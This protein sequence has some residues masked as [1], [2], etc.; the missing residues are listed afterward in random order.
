MSPGSRSSRHHRRP[1]ISSIPA[2]PAA[3]GTQ[4]QTRLGE[5]P[6]LRSPGR[7]LMHAAGRVGGGR[8]RTTGSA[9]G[10]RAQT[11]ELPHR[12]RFTADTA[13]VAPG[14]AP[15]PGDTA[16][17]PGCCAQDHPWTRG[18]R[19]PCGAEPRA[20]GKGAETGCRSGRA[21]A[22]GP[23]PHAHLALPASRYDARGSAAAGEPLRAPQAGGTPRQP[24]F[25]ASALPAAPEVSSLFRPGLPPASPLN[26]GVGSP[27]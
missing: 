22:L 14:L 25:S 12:Q 18:R 4:E 15:P 1:V 6:V 2:A 21:S 16:L 26:W 27:T 13:R 20:M 17:P 23:G 19:K 11:P 9:S 3:P 24:F 8:G 10:P 5:G 7:G